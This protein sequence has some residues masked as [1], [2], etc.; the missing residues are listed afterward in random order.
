MRWLDQTQRLTLHRRKKDNLHSAASPQIGEEA[1]STKNDPSVL[2]RSDDIEME[3]QSMSRRI[4]ISIALTMAACLVISSGCGK[5]YFKSASR[6]LEEKDYESAVAYLEL[7]AQE[8]DPRCAYR[9][10]SM[11]LAGEGVDQNSVEGARWMREAAEADLP[12]AQAYF[13][14]LYEIGEG[15]GKDLTAAAEWYR[16]AAE[17]GNPFG[18]AAFGAAAFYGV[19]VPEDSVEGYVWTKLAAK[20][21]FAK[22]V[23]NLPEMSDA[24]TEGQ[25]MQAERRIFRFRPKKNR[26]SDLDFDPVRLNRQSF[27]SLG[28]GSFVH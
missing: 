26:E 14:A 2:R 23:S 8:G 28:P 13:G 6:S 15:V 12:V 4:A 21:G 7:G 22:A 24:L 9:L 1:V 17:Y 10:G 16:K 20:Q 19:G 11:L 18:Q 3:E 25:R 5:G 27:K